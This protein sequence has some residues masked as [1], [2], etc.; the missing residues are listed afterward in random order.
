MRYIIIIIIA[1]LLV[2]LPI[3]LLAQGNLFRTANDS[4]RTADKLEHAG[5]DGLF[6]M[7]IYACGNSKP[8]AALGAVTFAVCWEV[9]DGFMPWERYGWWGGDGFSWR[10]VAAGACGVAVSW[11]MLE[12]LEWLQRAC[13]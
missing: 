13:A 2:L 5:R 8:L 3:P 4:F 9:K 10:D 7:L 6:F 12:F 11:V 1:C